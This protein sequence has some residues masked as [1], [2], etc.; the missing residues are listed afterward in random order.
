[1]THE[2][3]ADLDGLKNALKKA[4]WS[5]EYSDDPR[6]YSAGKKSVQIAQ[7][8]IAEMIKRYGKDD[9]DVQGIITRYGKDA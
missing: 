9:K 3:R 7:Y 2:K 1:M 8:V 5:Y 6:V 4:D